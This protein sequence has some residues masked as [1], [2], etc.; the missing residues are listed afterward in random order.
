[1]VCT[2]SVARIMILGC[3]TDPDEGFTVY[4]LDG[5]QGLG[6]GVSVGTL[7][8]KTVHIHTHICLTL[9]PIYMCVYI[10][11]Y[12]QSSSNLTCPTRSQIYLFHRTTAMQSLIQE[13]YITLNNL[14][15]FLVKRCPGGLWIHRAACICSE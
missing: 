12:T 8:S 7:F 13:F 10:C 1:M 2:G 3:F 5:V 6:Y 9:N 11:I 4:G 14:K 15:S